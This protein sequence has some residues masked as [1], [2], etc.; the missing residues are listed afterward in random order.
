MYYGTA[1]RTIQQQ[2]LRKEASEKSL[3]SARSRCRPKRNL[4][5]GVVAKGNTPFECLHVV[6]LES[7]VT[8]T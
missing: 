5:E 3:Q 7:Q 2:R 8:S 4:S 1:L 6:T